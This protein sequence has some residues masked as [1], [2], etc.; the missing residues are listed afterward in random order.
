MLDNPGWVNALVINF[1]VNGRAHACGGRA[2]SSSSECTSEGFS[3]TVLM[4]VG[5]RYR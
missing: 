1:C 2:N 4:R 3:E 5:I